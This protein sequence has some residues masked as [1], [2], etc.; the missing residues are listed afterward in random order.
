MEEMSKELDYVYRT[1]M[2]IIRHTNAPSET[3][4]HFCRRYVRDRV[5]KAAQGRQLD[6]QGKIIMM[7]KDLPWK[8]RK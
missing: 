4:V 5:L 3:V 2:A 7:L 8:I 6:I 1:H